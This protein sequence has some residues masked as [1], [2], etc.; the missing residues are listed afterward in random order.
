MFWRTSHTAIAFWL[1]MFS[2]VENH[3]IIFCVGMTFGCKSHSQIEAQTA[4]S[5][6]FVRK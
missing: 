2:A 1:S 3:D 6:T 4:E 5:L